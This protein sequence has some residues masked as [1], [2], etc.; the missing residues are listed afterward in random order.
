MI[1]TPT[2]PTPAFK[3]GEKRDNPV[4][5]YLADIFT[6]PANIARIPALSVP[7]GFVKVDNV[8]LPLGLQFMSAECRED[9]LFSVGKDF[10][11]E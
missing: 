8:D 3:L 6:V 9:L 1:I 11:N 2:T 10:L 5:M 4:E 7:S